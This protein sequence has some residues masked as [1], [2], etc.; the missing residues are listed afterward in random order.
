[1]SSIRN[2]K[3]TSETQ[4]RRIETQ[5]EINAPVADVWRA[6]TDAEWLT[7]WFPLEAR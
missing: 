5:Y 4:D 3:M 6:L 1:M 2:D 7:N